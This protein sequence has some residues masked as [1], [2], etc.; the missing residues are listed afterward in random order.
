MGWEGNA[1]YEICL[2][3]GGEF[4]RI[5]PRKSF[6]RVSGGLRGGVPTMG[7]Q[8]E[9]LMRFVAVLILSASL[10]ACAMGPY[11]YSG[12]QMIPGRLVNL[13]DGTIIPL[14][15]ELSTGQG[16]MGG[17]NPKTG[18][19]FDGN[20]TAIPETKYTQ[21]SQP[22][23]L[24]FETTHQSVEVSASVPATAILI[25]NQGTVINISVRIKPGDANTRPIGYGEGTDNKGGKYNFQF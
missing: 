19:V 15:L 18:E 5:A 21:V 12:G 23:F 22:G 1:N 8:Q 20:Y 13:T 14:Q 2:A 16:R 25:G 17:T 7:I 11:M 10:T 9:V 3:L 6:G 4:A 24:G